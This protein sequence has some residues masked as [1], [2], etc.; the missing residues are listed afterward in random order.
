MS[1]SRVR[2]LVIGVL[3]LAL[4]AAAALFGV[5]WRYSA[6]LLDSPLPP[7]RNNLT[8]T[9]VTAGTVTLTATPWTQRTGTFGLDWPGGTAVVSRIVGRPT[10]RTVTRAVRDRRGVLRPGTKAHLTNDVWDSDPRQARGLAFRTVRIAEPLGP[11]PAWYVAGS[12]RTW[13]L[14]VHGRGDTMSEGLRVMPALHRL[15]LPMLDISY[16]NDPGAPAGPG[17]LY[18]LGGSEWR[19]V[20]AAVRYATAHGARHVVLYGWSMGGA[21]VEA[22]VR[23][24]HLSSR[25]SA[26]V[27]DSPVV[28][29][30]AVLN[31]QA[32]QRHLPGVVTWAAE[33]VVSWR[34]GINWDDFDVVAHPQTITVPTLLFAGKS[35]TLVPYAPTAR[36]AAERPRLITF[37]PVPTADHT[38]AWN[39]DPG[40]YDRRLAGFLRRHALPAS[41]VG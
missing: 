28:D 35:D 8:V 11:T 34:I 16:R 26:V 18:H 36:L 20:A 14:L 30:R 39:I 6:V 24:S 29:W 38:E 5:G 13:V 27:L 22:F 37:Y 40:A 31:L 21:I 9:A 3:V 23:H 19:D 12:S 10:S 33:R 2:L 32:N 7:D 15:G 41:A 17:R 4:V 25:V 1:A